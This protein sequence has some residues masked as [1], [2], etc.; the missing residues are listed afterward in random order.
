MCT[1]RVLLSAAEMR[2]SFFPL[3]CAP[4]FG[5]LKGE[6]VLLRALRAWLVQGSWSC[7]NSWSLAS[8]SA[9]YLLQALER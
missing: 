8:D 1:G 5:R 6:P 3:S 2:G 4:S 7:A 9:M